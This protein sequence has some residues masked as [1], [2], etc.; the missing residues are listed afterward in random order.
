MTS[1][2]P[3]G[4]GTTDPLLRIERHHLV[5]SHR[6]QLAADVRRGLTAVPKRLPPKYFY[7]ERGSQ[8]F[9]AICAL[10]EYY[11]T[12]TE[13]ALLDTVAGDII[14]RVRP[15]HLVELGSGAS[16][17]TRVLLDAL[18]AVTAHPTYVPIDVSGEMLQRSAERL[19]AA[20]PQLR[21]QAVIADFER[22]LPPLPADGAR[23]VAFLGSS[24]GNYEPPA[25]RALL[26]AVA[27]RLRPGDALLLGVDL[28]KPV[29][30]LQAAYDDA[31]GVT[32]EFNR[33]VLLVINRMLDA[34]FD[35]A[36]FA[37]VAEYNP[38]REQIE[39]RLR[40]RVA[41]RVRIAALDLEIAFA[42]GETIHTE[43]CRKFRRQGV[44]TLLRSAGFG[45]VDWFASPGDAFALALGH[46][47]ARA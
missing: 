32:A 2:S 35:P 15:R 41:H 12:R 9:D 33:N 23:L 39:I 44:E 47:E 37:H 13:Q 11:L 34:D 31:A 10:P 45:A 42:A 8:L 27:A 20:Y 28:V 1:A 46:V 43:S 6:E 19:R 40:A 26:S 30:I 4:P 24:I 36:R 5:A 3:T 21:V 18:V 29:A 38:A 17:K 16:R 7:D 14:A 22:A 25:D